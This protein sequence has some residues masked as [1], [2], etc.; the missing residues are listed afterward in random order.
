MVQSYNDEDWHF[1]LPEIHVDANIVQQILKTCITGATIIKLTKKTR[2]LP[3]YT[4]KMYLFYL[5]TFGLIS[6]HGE[7]K[8][9]K[10]TRDGVII[11]LM[12][13]DSDRNPNS[14]NEDIVIYN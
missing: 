10:L 5:V 6:Y 7:K 8:I 9:Y 13:N 14:S 1:V 12:I 4:L 3:Y 2:N 11:L